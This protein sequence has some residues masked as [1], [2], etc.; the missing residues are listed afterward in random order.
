[1]VTDANTG[2]SFN[3]YVYASNCP[4]EYIDP[5]GRQS[6][7]ACGQCNR[8][9]GEGWVKAYEHITA[10]VTS[11]PFIKITTPLMGPEMAMLG[12]GTKLRSSASKAETVLQYSAIV[13]CGGTNTAE[14]FSVGV[15]S[16]AKPGP[17]GTVSGISVNSANGKTVQELSQTIPNKQ[18][19][20]TTVGEIRQAGGN[21][22]SKPT[23]NN[24]NHCEMCGLPPQQAEKIFTPTQPNQR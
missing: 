6:I 19:G 24:P 7:K 11:D 9:N 5:D 16:G 15:A 8:T 4:Y 3:R 20:V 23:T 12:A 22:V 21:V 2:S 13:V 10:I 17:N 18:V 1:M 14:R